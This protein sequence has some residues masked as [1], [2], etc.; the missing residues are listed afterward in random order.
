MNRDRIFFMLFSSPTIL[1]VK[2][3]SAGKSSW[4][5][6]FF[7]VICIPIHPLFRHEKTGWK[8][9]FEALQDSRVPS[10]P[11]GALHNGQPSS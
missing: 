1:L 5:L 9:D 11:T 10:R 6:Q 4:K 8:L 2:R 3:W 7:F